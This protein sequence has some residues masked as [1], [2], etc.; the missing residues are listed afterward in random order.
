MRNSADR[1]KLRRLET[2]REK[3]MAKGSYQDFAKL[4]RKFLDSRLLA[5][6]NEYGSNEKQIVSKEI[7]EILKNYMDVKR[8]RFKTCCFTFF[9]KT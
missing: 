1:I 4:R 9:F 7:D 8:T 2:V 5:L 6:N 3:L